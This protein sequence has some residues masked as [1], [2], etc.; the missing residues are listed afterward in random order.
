MSTEES[1]NSDLDAA[2]FALDALDASER[3]DLERRRS[4]NPELDELISAHEDTV[5][6]LAE[7]STPVQPPASMR[8]Q[9]LAMIEEV[10]QH[11][12]IHQPGAP[13][14]FPEAPVLPDTAATPPLPAPSTDATTAVSAVRGRSQRPAVVRR[15]RGLFAGIAVLAA[16]ALFIGGVVTGQLRAGD[17]EA[18]VDPALSSLLASPDLERRSEPVAGGGTATV[19]W[20]TQTGSAA[21]AVK[22]VAPLDAAQVYELWFIGAEGA[23]PAGTFNTAKTEGTHWVLL[24]G[25]MSPGDA[26]GLTVEPRGGSEQPTT[27]PILVVQS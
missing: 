21:I 18:G 13:R 12:A 24:E 8:A 16:A 6:A 1:R 27:D 17:A 10:P 23:A 14:D 15:R 25:T 7:A 20:S 4:E 19:V 2:A 3:A 11:A 26:V 22:D 9:L 5:I